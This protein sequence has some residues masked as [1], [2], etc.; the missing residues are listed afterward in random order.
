MKNK[1]KIMDHQPHVSDD[2]IEAYKDFSAVLDAHREALKGTKTPAYRKWVVMG[3]LF[4]VATV[5]IT[6]F[7]TARE[8]PRIRAVLPPAPVIMPEAKKDEVATPLHDTRKSNA[9]ASASKTGN[10][11]SSTGHQPVTAPQEPAPTPETPPEIGY[12]QAEPVNGYPDLYNYLSTNLVYPAEALKDSVQGVLTVSFMVNRAGRAEKIEVLNSLGPAFDEEVKRLIE[13]M[14]Q[15]KPAV[16]NGRPIP[17]KM[18]LPITFRYTGNQ[19]K[20]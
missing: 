7:M 8:Q 14:P 6:W 13:G 1:L 2:E 11:Q 20:D 17:S 5:S 9:T 15:W 12:I 16:L 3:A 4:V 10:T 18:S 19:I